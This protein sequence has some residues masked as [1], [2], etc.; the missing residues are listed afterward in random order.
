MIELPDE[1][2]VAALSLVGWAAH[3]MRTPRG[4]QRWFC[5]RHHALLAQKLEAVARGEIRRLMVFMPPR[6]GKSVLTS[7]AFTSWYLGRYPDRNVILTSYEARF[8]EGWGRKAR[9]TFARFAPSVFGVRPKDTTRAGNWWEIEGHAGAFM[10][11]GA[12]GPLTGKG[13]SIMVIDDPHKSGEEARSKV[14]RDKVWDWWQSTAHNRIEP[15]ENG[16]GDSAVLIQTRWHE[17]DLAGHLLEEMKTGGERWE[18]LNLPAIAEDDDPLG[19]EPGEALWPEK[20]PLE[21]L[22]EARRSASIWWHAQYQGRPSSAA[23]DVFKR[24]WFRYYRETKPGTFELEVPRTCHLDGLARFTTVDLAASTKASADYTVITT[25]GVTPDGHVLV[26]GVLRARLEGPDIVPAI[27]REVER[28]KSRT[29]WIEKVAFQLALVQIAR[30]AGLPVRELERARGEDKRARAIAATPDLEA[31]KVWFPSSAS[32][33]AEW[34]HE[35][36]AF[37]G[38]GEQAH[39]DQVD[40]FSDGVIIARSFRS[41]GRPFPR[42]GRTLVGEANEVLGPS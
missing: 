37:R 14:M 31:G 26:L 12:A 40:T 13:A 23:G 11:A 4:R 24:E 21:R 18:V 30:R 20:W 3:V 39:D 16:E 35:L 34:E 25:F 28:W 2:K 19:R 6:H 41:G 15:D 33:L 8:A 5:Y 38:E 9:D 36:L 27:A 22:E 29:V 7:H 42:K 17:E 1:R 32:W 10:T